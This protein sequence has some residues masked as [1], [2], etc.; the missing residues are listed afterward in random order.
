MHGDLPQDGFCI[1]HG[2]ISPDDIALLRDV[3]EPFRQ[4][5]TAG[6][7]ALLRDSPQ[8]AAF[9]ERFGDSVV[10]PLLG[11]RAW[12]VRAILFDKTPISNWY[13]TWHQDR[14]IPVQRKHDTPGF[15]AWSEKDGVTHVQPPA[16][17]LDSMIAA[18]IALDA[19]GTTDGAIKFI[20]GSHA[21]GVMDD[22]TIAEWRDTRNATTVA[23]E[24]GDVIM[25]RP[26]ILHA[27]SKADTATSRRVLHIE[28]ATV[29]LPN[30]LQWAKG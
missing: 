15:T 19:C 30:E 17:V 23:T 27:S 4:G 1:L 28:Y 24:A 16:A 5:G 12:P 18:R 21:H 3:L 7:R 26:L 9:A 29:Q 22:A 14:T 11:A 2:A 13:V 20:A 8:I 10:A 6:V 25:M